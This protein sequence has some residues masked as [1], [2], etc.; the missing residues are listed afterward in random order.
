MLWILAMMMAGLGLGYV[1]IRRKRK[2]SQ[3][4]A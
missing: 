1:Q 2:G 3:K 4:T